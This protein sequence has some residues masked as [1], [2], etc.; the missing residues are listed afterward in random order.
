[1]VASLRLEVSLIRLRIRKSIDLADRIMRNVYWNCCIGDPEK[2]QR[3]VWVKGTEVCVI[4]GQRN[5][6]SVSRKKRASQGKNLRITNCQNRCKEKENFSY[7]TG[8][9]KEGQKNLTA[10]TPV[11]KRCH[12]VRC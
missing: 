2:A 1:M 9:E 3:E 5:T 10:W 12:F 4:N 11:P 8:K 7:K 6:C